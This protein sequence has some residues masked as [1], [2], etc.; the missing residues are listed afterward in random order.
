MLNNQL[1]SRALDMLTKIN[2]SI[3]ITIIMYCNL[4]HYIVI[5][6]LCDH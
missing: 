2:I 6:R 5:V 4:S 3:I 1:I